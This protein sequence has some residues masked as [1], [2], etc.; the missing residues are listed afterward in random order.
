MYSKGLKVADTRAF[1]LGIRGALL[2]LSEDL[3]ESQLHVLIYCL[4]QEVPGPQVQAR[5][6]EGC[7]EDTIIYLLPTNDSDN[8][9]PLPGSR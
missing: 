9:S 3:G 2:C 5:Q 7:Q 1:I 8:H 4:Q 6:R